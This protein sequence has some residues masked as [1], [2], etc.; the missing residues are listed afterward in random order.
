MT[1]NKYIEGVV[2]ELYNK[3]PYRYRK[4]P[5]GDDGLDNVRTA[6]TNAYNQGEEDR[7]E[8]I[9]R[10]IDNV[11]KIRYGNTNLALKDLKEALTTKNK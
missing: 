8:S 2:E 10:M 5:N 4:M 7:G 9:I 6:L 3:N 1:K 11:Q